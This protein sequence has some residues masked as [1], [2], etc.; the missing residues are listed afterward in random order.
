[1]FLGIT[2]ARSKFSELVERALNGETI[3][4]AKHGEVLLTFTPTPER[5]KFG[6][7]EGKSFTSSLFFFYSFS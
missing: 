6:Q 1:M 7:F 4:I 5:R 3:Q 2:E